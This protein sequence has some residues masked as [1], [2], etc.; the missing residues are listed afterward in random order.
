MGV[1]YQAGPSGRSPFGVNGL[2]SRPASRSAHLSLATL[3]RDRSTWDR[4][5]SHEP[6][7]F[8]SNTGALTWVGAPRPTTRPLAPAAKAMFTSMPTRWRRRHSSSVSGRAQSYASSNS[9]SPGPR[10]WKRGRSL[11]SG[12]PSGASHGAQ[13]TGSL[14]RLPGLCSECRLPSASGAEARV[15]GCRAVISSRPVTAVEPRGVIT[16]DA[17]TPRRRASSAGGSRSA[18]PQWRL[19]SACQDGMHSCTQARSEPCAGR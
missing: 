6:G 15:G 18:P 3:T 8:A 14:P 12:C 4:S 10:T 1:A 9:F 13:S 5:T 17:Y 11:R 16:R 7:S 2:G 19:S